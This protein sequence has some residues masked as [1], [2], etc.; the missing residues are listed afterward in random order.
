MLAKWSAIGSASNL[1]ATVRPRVV[2]V[3]SISSDIFAAEA[4]QFRLKMSTDR[5]FVASFSSLNVVNIL[6]ISRTS[7]R[8]HL[9]GLGEVLQHETHLIRAEKLNS[10]T[11]FSMVHITK[12]F[13]AALHQFATSPQTFDF[14][15]HAR[16]TY[17]VS[18]TFQ[19]HLNTFMNL[20][21]E[22]N[23]PSSVIW[24]F[25]ASVVILDSFP[26]DIHS[27]SHYNYSL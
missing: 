25:I 8:Q 18:Q 16:E 13:D 17:P 15:Q 20:C 1:S 21:S 12:F 3:T 24:E 7:P 4:L 10:H 5:Q 14:I 27:K 6:D 2:V 9:E 19:H 26:P 22:N 11:L 23:T